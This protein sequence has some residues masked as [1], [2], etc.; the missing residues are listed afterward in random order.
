MSS[1]WAA[2]RGGARQPSDCGLGGSTGG[3]CTSPLQPPRLADPSLLRIESR[4]RHG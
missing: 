4:L 3:N 2:A 1:R